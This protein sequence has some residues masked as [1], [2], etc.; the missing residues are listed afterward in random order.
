MYYLIY[1]FFYLL[2]LIPWWLM[3]LISDGLYV[4]VYYVFG[5][6]KV[7]VMKNLSIAF[8]EKTEKERIRIAKDF[9]KSFVDSFV[10]MVKLV[11]I[12]PSEFDRRYSIDVEILNQ[13]YKTGQNVQLHSGHFFNWEFMN[14]GVSKNSP[15][16]LIGIFTALSNPNFNRLIKKIRS[17]FGTILISTADFRTHFH[18]YT[19]QPYSLG[20]V[21]DQNPVDPANAYWV[22]FFGKLTP[23]VKGPEKGAKSKN[24]AVVM[25]DL[26]KVKR[27]YYQTDLTLLTTTP[28]ETPTGYITKKLIAHIEESVKKRPHNYLWS[29]R[30]WK[31]EFDAEK[32]G[33]YVIE[34]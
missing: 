4:L 12:S 28:K 10:E 26:Y 13:L 32:F 7:V 11:S 3:Y 9:Y 21:A 22:P 20:L 18:Q 17:Q 30:R 14:L 29:H 1:G 5:Y 6:R 24:T 34:D 15:Y 27:G 31:F 8:P 16:P 19:T 33:K 23:F 25:V 2:S